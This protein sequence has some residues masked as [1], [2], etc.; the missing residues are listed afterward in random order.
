MLREASLK[1]DQTERRSDKT[2][3]KDF[4]RMLEINFK[5]IEVERRKTNYQLK[6]VYLTLS[7][8]FPENTHQH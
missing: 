4:D 7:K 3:E 5:D 8:I 1:T 2:E 6:N